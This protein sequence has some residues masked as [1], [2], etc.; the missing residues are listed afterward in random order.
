MKIYVKSS[1]NASDM[2]IREFC[3][4]IEDI[5]HQKFPDSLCQAR[6]GTNFDEHITVSCRL[7]KDGSE[8][9]S[10]ILG[11]DIFHVMAFINFLSNSVDEIIPLLDNLEKENY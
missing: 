6:Y 3:Q 5:Y 11:N 8:V 2:T 4:A 9:S 10:N 7:A 1:V